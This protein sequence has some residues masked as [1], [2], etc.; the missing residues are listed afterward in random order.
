MSSTINDSI[1]ASAACIALGSLPGTTTFSIFLTLVANST[2]PATAQDRESTSAAANSTICKYSRAST[3]AAVYPRRLRQLRACQRI[4]LNLITRLAFAGAARRPT[5]FDGNDGRQRRRDE[6]RV[7]R[8]KRRLIDDCPGIAYDFTSC[9]HS[10]SAGSPSL[11]GPPGGP[12]PGAVYRRSTSPPWT[13]A[14]TDDV[15]LVLRSVRPQTEH[16]T[17]RVNPERRTSLPRGSR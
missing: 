9:R 4:T 1:S 11:F 13:A 3:N 8:S 5:R 17:C 14:P 15:A 12:L 7:P 16:T 6:P 10:G 2:D